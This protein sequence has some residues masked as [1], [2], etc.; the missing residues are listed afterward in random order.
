MQFSKKTKNI[1]TWIFFI[2]NPSVQRYLIILKVNTRHLMTPCSL[3]RSSFVEAKSIYSLFL[4]WRA[5]FTSLWIFIMSLE[6]KEYAMDS[7]LDFLTESFNFWECHFTLSNLKLICAKTL[8][9]MNTMN[10]FLSRNNSHDSMLPKSY[11]QIFFFCFFFPRWVAVN[12]T[13]R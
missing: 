11:W 1:Y 9:S 5:I 8:N 6:S 4:I 10:W 2:T 12:E 7:A 13:V 3:H